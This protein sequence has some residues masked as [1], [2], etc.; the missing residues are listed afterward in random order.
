MHVLVH[1]PQFSHHL[2]AR[3]ALRVAVR[4][5]TLTVHVD[6]GH[7]SANVS[8]GALVVGQETRQYSLDAL[9]PDTMATAACHPPDQTCG[10]AMRV[11]CRI[12]DGT[13]H[14]M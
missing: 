4:L 1:C 9:S 12:F 2:F 13:A 6:A 10:A 5:V 11:V 3:S 8:G 7:T 14:D